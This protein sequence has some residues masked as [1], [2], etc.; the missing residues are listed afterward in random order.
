MTLGKRQQRGA[1]LKI[2][3]VK[4]DF[5]VGTERAPIAD[6]GKKAAKSVTRKMQSYVAIIKRRNCG[7]L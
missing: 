7:H 1:Y 4:G 6:E 5:S 2:Q 3:E